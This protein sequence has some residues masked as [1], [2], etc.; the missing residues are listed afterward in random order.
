MRTD[1]DTSKQGADGML[2]SDED[3]TEK[4]LEWLLDMDLSE[5]EESLFT[6]TGDEYREEG[7]SAYEAEV[8]GRPLVRGND[9]G[10]DLANY[11]EEEIVISS[12]GAPGDIYSGSSS[13][14]ADEEDVSDATA[15]ALDHSRARKQDTSAAKTDVGEGADILG[16][17]SED[18]MGE[19]LMAIRRLKPARKEREPSSDEAIAAVTAETSVEGIVEN[20][21]VSPVDDVIEI[22]VEDT[23]ADAIGSEEITA[24]AD[25]GDSLELDALEMEL[26]SDTV[27]MVLESGSLEMEL[28]S[29]DSL[30]EEDQQAET[31]QSELTMQWTEA[32]VP[33]Q[34]ADPG[35][36]VVA[37]ETP[38]AIEAQEP[39]TVTDYVA[40][41]PDDDDDDAFDEF[42]L[43]GSHL[44]GEDH[45]L[46]ALSMDDESEEE[47]AGEEVTELETLVDVTAENVVEAGEA[48]V[49]N[50]EEQQAEKIGRA[51]CRERV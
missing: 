17:E 25:T 23:K 21:V 34:V 29:D 42:L 49:D 41:M 19:A 33:T 40:S 14:D 8:A 18:D 45:D 27:E 13:A 44:V 12:A 22:L 20:S 50:R 11:V 2:D 6:V 46:E 24:A 9:G 31:E 16:L 7:L 10:D 43:A 28:E 30:L 48:V 15:M 35:N 3:N 51:S 26:D 39:V 47:L 38:V 36:D 4:G 37:N 5:P 32:P 1:N